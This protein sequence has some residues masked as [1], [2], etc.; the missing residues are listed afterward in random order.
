MRRKLLF[1]VTLCLLTASCTE[2]STQE[3]KRNIRIG[4]ALYD[5]YDTFISSLFSKFSSYARQ[6]EQE[7]GITITIMQGSADGN[8]LVQNSQVESFIEAGCDVLCVNLVDRTDAAVI[9]DMAGANQI[10]V[11]FFNRELVEEDLER[12][13]KL[14]YVGADALESGR[15]QGQIAADLWK[16]NIEGIDKNGDEIMQYV[17]LEGEAGHQDAIMR[18]EYSITEV[19]IAGIKLER[20]GHEIA[21]WVR[22]QAETKMSQWLETHGG[23][24]EVVFANNDDMALGA[25]DALKRAE[26]PYKDWPMIMG[27]DGTDAGRDAVIRGEMTGTVFNDAKGQAESMMDLAYALCVGSQLP[28]LEDGRYIRLPYQAITRSNVMEFGE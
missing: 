20:L 22:S 18:T 7:S 6:V 8:Q 26:I 10:P 11:I 9:I 16:D 2:T 12:E 13:D 5:Q 25:I 3:P 4:V 23:S 14:Y 15:I 28:E 1:I 24:I 21:N 27:I 17:M 19:S